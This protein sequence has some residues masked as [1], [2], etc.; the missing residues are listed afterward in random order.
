[1]RQALVE[2][3]VVIG[4]GTTDQAWF[5][6]VPIGKH[7][8]I[9]LSDVGANSAFRAFESKEIVERL[10]PSIRAL[11]R[12]LIELGVMQNLAL[13]RLRSKR[14]DGRSDEEIGCI[15]LDVN[16]YSIFTEFAGNAFPA[17]I[18]DTYL[19]AMSRAVAQ[20]GAP[21]HVVG[22]EVY[23]VIVQ[24]FLP[25][26][27]SVTTALVEAIE[28][29]DDFVFG[30][31][32]NLCRAAGYEPVTVSIG[33]NVGVATIICDALQVRTTGQVVNEA[34]RLLDEAGRNGICV[35]A[36][37]NLD[38]SQTSFQSSPPISYLRKKNLISGRRLRR[39][40]PPR[41][42]GNRIAKSRYAIGE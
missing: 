41:T 14:G 6:V 26:G 15:F 35:H 1:M 34:K 16:D 32:A 27:M 29:I 33:A 17:F 37:V 30:E 21:E 5:L 39:M 23:F 36:G 10:L 12:R 20:W 19:P 9:N 8:C 24:D 11:D 4:R 22:D 7:A 40:A 38:L 25:Q 2:N 28:G 42:K 3:Q 13:Q 18:G 31:G